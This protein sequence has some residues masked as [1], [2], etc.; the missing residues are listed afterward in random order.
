MIAESISIKER[1]SLQIATLEKEATNLA[2]QVSE[3]KSQLHIAT[4]EHESKIERLKDHYER[5]NKVTVESE[6]R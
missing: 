6:K 5:K 4:K 2:K 3:A 1:H